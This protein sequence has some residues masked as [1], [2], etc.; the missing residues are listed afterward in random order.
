MKPLNEWGHISNTEG[1][2]KDA[3]EADRQKVFQLCIEAGSGIKKVLEIKEQTF[4]ANEQITAEQQTN[5]N[6]L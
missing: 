5:R 6:E 3:I 1:K 2:T 4:P